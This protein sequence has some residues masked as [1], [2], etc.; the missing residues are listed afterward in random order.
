VVQEREP[1]AL[2]EGLLVPLLS[3][4]RCGISPVIDI[5]YADAPQADII[6]RIIV[7]FSNDLINRALRYMLESV[8][9][10]GTACG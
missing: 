9:A 7:D 4:N 1:G 3:L 10:N 8:P 5:D 6:K 2:L